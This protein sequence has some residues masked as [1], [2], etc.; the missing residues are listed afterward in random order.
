M[1]LARGRLIRRYASFSLL[2]EKIM[3]GEILRQI[4][5]LWFIL[6]ALFW[7]ITILLHVLFAAGVA[8]DAGTLRRGGSSTVLVSPMAWVFATLLGGSSWLECIG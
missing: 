3:D 8:R 6:A 1:L 5:Q 2:K 7:G 4:P